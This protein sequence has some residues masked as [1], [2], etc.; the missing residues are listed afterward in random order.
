MTASAAAAIAFV[1]V[2]GP[3]SGQAPE[4]R[5]KQIAEAEK[6]LA[7]LQKQLEE[8]KKQPSAG[9]AAISGVNGSLPADW[10]K[11]MTWRNIGPA[12]MGGRVTA[13]SV[14]EADPTTYWVA[15]A[16]GGLLKTTNNG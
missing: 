1:I 11:S 9:E 2:P 5:A 14:F 3:L 13:I 8:L 12:N 16:S 6:R 15:S 10:V 4:D 7:D